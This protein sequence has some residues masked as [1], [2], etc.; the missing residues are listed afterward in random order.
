MCLDKEAEGLQRQME[1][2]KKHNRKVK[3]IF[4]GIQESFE[5]HLK[6]PA[7]DGSPAS[8]PLHYTAELCS[9]VQESWIPGPLLGKGR[10]FFPKTLLTFEG[11]SIPSSSARKN[12][13]NGDS[14]KGGGKGY[15][16]ALR[17]KQSQ[18][19]GAR[20]ERHSVPEVNSDIHYHS[21][22]KW[23]NRSLRVKQLAFLNACFSLP[24]HHSQSPFSLPISI[25]K[26]FSTARNVPSTE[27]REHDPAQSR[28]W[29]EYSSSKSTSSYTTASCV[30]RTVIPRGLEKGVRKSWNTFSACGQVCPLLSLSIM[31]WSFSSLKFNSSCKNPL[32]SYP[33]SLTRTF[34]TCSVSCCFCKRNPCISHS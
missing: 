32:T 19:S 12:G 4:T 25:L 11:S 29:T 7:N 17:R 15:A 6:S 22:E 9:A 27:H 5:P 14:F 20:V 13:D 23:H 24:H 1:G 26:P 8:N 3:Q 21:P 31:S 2:R 30:M 34:Y 10:D 33:R 16:W 28:N 18:H